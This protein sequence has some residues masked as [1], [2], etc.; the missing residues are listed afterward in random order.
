MRKQT[1]FADFKAEVGGAQRLCVRPCYVL[2]VRVCLC[3][4]MCVPRVVY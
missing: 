2:C 3:V 4:C 1:K